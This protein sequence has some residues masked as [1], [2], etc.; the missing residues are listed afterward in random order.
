MENWSKRPMAVHGPYFSVF[1]FLCVRCSSLLGLLRLAWGIGLQTWLGFG[2]KHGSLLTVIKY[3][4]IV[5]KYLP[6][7]ISSLIFWFLSFIFTLF[8]SIT[9]TTSFQAGVIGRIK[10]PIAK[11]RPFGNG[12]SN[13]KSTHV[14][15]QICL[16]I[17]GISGTWSIK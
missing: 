9:N 11:V 1:S 5:Q 12:W 3:L 14:Q 10:Y 6:K 8:Y 15:K 2:K 4:R 16:T 17:T 13:F 7:E